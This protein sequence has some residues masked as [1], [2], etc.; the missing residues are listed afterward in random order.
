MVIV[1]AK[2]RLQPDKVD[3]FLEAYRWMKPQ[4]LNDPGAI[5]YS[6][7]RSA[8]NPAEFMMYEQY[9]NEEAFAYHMSTEHC[10]TLVE[11]IDPL[12]ALPVQVASWVE[13]I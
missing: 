5:Q 1:T 2:M 12:M 11:R 13:V 8:E 7:H 3:E 4:V 10:R 6:L 9:E